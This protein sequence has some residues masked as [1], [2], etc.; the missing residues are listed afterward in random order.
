MI[1]LDIKAIQGAILN[2]LDTITVSDIIFDGEIFAINK[3]IKNI[4]DNQ[5]LFNVN[6][7]ILNEKGQIVGKIEY[8]NDETG[9]DLY[10]I[11]LNPITQEEIKRTLVTSDFTILNSPDGDNSTMFDLY[12]SKKL[13]LYLNSLDDSIIPCVHQFYLDETQKLNSQFNSAYDTYV[14]SFNVF[15]LDNNPIKVTV[16][17]RFVNNDFYKNKYFICMLSEN[18]NIKL[19]ALKSYNF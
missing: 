10:H 3:N 17:L 18:T 6:S 19:S 15:D 8:I 1:K 16:L 11:D 7:K 14:N 9:S 2:I 4:N 5:D 13:N 12:G